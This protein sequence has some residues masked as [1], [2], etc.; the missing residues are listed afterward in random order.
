MSESAA[1]APLQPFNFAT[2]SGIFP[3]TRTQLWQ[4]LRLLPL[5]GA[6]QSACWA[7]L[8]WYDTPRACVLVCQNPETA[9]LDATPLLRLEEPAPANLQA[10]LASALAERGWQLYNCGACAHWRLGAESPANALQLTADGLALGAC[11]LRRAIGPMHAPNAVPPA[12]QAQ[13]HLA[14]GCAHWQAAGADDN[15]SAAETML[16][17]ARLPKIAE[18]TESKLK[19]LARWRLRIKRRLSPPAPPST[20]TDLLA[21]RSGVGAGT[22]PCAVCQGRIANLGALTTASP[23][24]DKETFSVWRCRICHSLYLSDWVDRW[25]R[26]DSLETEERI[27]RIA[28]VEAAELLMLF[29]SIPAAEHPERRHERNAQR[30][31]I[32]NEMAQRTPLSHIIKQ[33]R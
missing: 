8:L 11:S 1:A 6:Q 20:L 12:L 13:S 23:E 22:E 24:D 33:G 7:L 16:P 9:Q 25:E 19:P 28:P 10:R 30:T 21:E 15:P 2:M 5:E 18:T 32:H 17:V 3:G 27:F 29:A 31:W 4:R 14:L 26:V